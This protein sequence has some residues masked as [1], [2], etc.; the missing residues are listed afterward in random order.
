[1]AL[2]F[3]YQTWF[4]VAREEPTAWGVERGTVRSP[5][6]ADQL[7]RNFM[8]FKRGGDG[9][10]I[11]IR[12]HEPNIV[13]GIGV[14]GDS[15]QLGG[16]PSN[17]GGG[18]R[19]LLRPGKKDLGGSLGIEV[20]YEG[21]ELLWWMALGKCVTSGAGP[22]L[23]TITIDD[24]LSDG[25]TSAATQYIDGLTLWLLR[26]DRTATNSVWA[27]RGTRVSSFEL[28][29]QKQGILNATFNVTSSDFNRKTGFG[30]HI[31]ATLDTPAP[32]GVY[33]FSG[34]TIKWRGVTLNVEDVNFKW[35][36]GLATERWVA[37]LYTRSEQ[38][39]DKKAT[40]TVTCNVEYYDLY[41]S[42][43][44]FAD[45]ATNPALGSWYLEFL[46]TSPYK[47]VIRGATDQA[48]IKNWTPKV[49]DEGRIK[50]QLEFQLYRNAA[51]TNPEF[52]I[53]ITNQRQ[54]LIPY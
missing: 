21:S 18:S 16:T 13:S 32:V 5:T 10:E 24:A 44:L 43:D 38:V 50:G 54:K 33:L 7:Y 52:Q 46:G 3:G 41:G 11:K 45:Y 26:A 20:P 15:P 40:A 35:D 22:Y 37:G 48:R 17:P 51:N 14:Y 23:H 53:E 49:V 4:A 30:S 2:S 39:R 36:N 47:F 29:A 1:M 34:G 42:V 27:C 28:S 25:Q 19:W 12:P 6:G 8:Y 9:Y 31:A